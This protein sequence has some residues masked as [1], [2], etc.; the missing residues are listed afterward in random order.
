M[1]PWSKVL[2][3]GSTFASSGLN[4]EMPM[5]E[6]ERAENVANQSLLGLLL[7]NHLK[8]ELNSKYTSNGSKQPL[9]TQGLCPL[10]WSGEGPSHLIAHSPLCRGW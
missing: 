6:K 1:G 3:A 2:D 4:I 10:P 9:A 5:R 8:L 7:K